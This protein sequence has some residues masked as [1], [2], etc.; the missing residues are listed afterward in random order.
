MTRNYNGNVNRTLIRDLRKLCD[1][2]AENERLLFE[3]FDPNGEVSVYENSD[4]FTG[5][6]DEISDAIT[7]KTET[8]IR[9]YLKKDLQKRVD[10][11]LDNI[12][13]AEDYLLSTL[14]EFIKGNGRFP[15]KEE[16]IKLEKDAEAKRIAELPSDSVAAPKEIT[17]QDIAREILE[18][19]EEIMESRRESNPDDIVV[20]CDPYPEAYWI[21]TEEFQGNILHEMYDV[22]KDFHDYQCKIKIKGYH[23]VE[24]ISFSYCYGGDNTVYVTAKDCLDKEM[25]I[26]ITDYLITIHKGIVEMAKAEEI[27]FTSEI[28][29]E[30]FQ[31]A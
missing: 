22:E 25:N 21:E 16:R 14:I 3:K 26:P 2:N 7:M 5:C 28:D 10:R 1:V 27:D 23:N 9:E 8:E 30:K 15:E 20:R 11:Y 17:E 4:I 29:Y 13:P 6:Y 12:K 18:L 31:I 19:A 24:T